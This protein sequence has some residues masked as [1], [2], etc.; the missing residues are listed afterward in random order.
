LKPFGEFVHSGGGRD[1]VICEAMGRR[2]TAVMFDARGG[3]PQLLI[4]TTVRRDADFVGARIVQQDFPRTAAAMFPPTVILAAG[5]NRN[6]REDL[7]P[8]DRPSA[9]EALWPP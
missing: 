3:P 4:P 6:R 8:S 5:P 7:P 9:E 2:E 1:I